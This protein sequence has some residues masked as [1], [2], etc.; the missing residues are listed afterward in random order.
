MLLSGVVTVPPRAIVDPLTVIPEFTRAV[1]GMFDQVLLDP[2]KT[3]ESKVLF[4]RVCD[5]FK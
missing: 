4:V 5:A 1:F 3:Q 2:D